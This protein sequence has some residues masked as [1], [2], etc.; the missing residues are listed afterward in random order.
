MVSQGQPGGD[1]VMTDDWMMMRDSCAGESHQWRC[2]HMPTEVALQRLVPLWIFL[3]Q[4]APWGQSQQFEAENI[5]NTQ[6]IPA[7]PW[8]KKEGLELRMCLLVRD[9]FDSTLKRQSICIT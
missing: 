4:Q 8:S 7:K 9:G 6:K 1:D 2:G 5:W 3:P